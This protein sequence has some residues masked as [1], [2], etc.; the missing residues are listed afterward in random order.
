MIIEPR[1][2]GFICT[3]AHP[4]GCAMNVRQQVGYVTAKAPIPGAP[5]RVLVLGCSAGYGLA[6]RIVATFGGGGGHGGGLLREAPERNQDRQR[7]LVQQPGLR[8]RGR[9]GRAQGRDPGRA[10]PFPTP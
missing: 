5:K 9:Q 8:G 4:A 2:R 6:S 10:T 1:I 3:T 7:R